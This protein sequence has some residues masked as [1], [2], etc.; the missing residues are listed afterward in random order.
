[1]RATTRILHFE[2]FGSRKALRLANSALVAAVAPFTGTAIILAVCGPN[3]GHLAGQALFRALNNQLFVEFPFIGASGGTFGKGP[4]QIG[5]LF[6]F[7][8][9][10]ALIG[11]PSGS[12]GRRSGA[13][14]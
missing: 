11:S 1:M 4:G 2:V 8:G 5:S 10:R 7:P 9:F 3:V 6:G 12:G 13:A 14:L